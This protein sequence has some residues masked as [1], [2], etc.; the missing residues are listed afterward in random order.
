M[1]SE[2]SWQTGGAG[3]TSNPA[4]ADS[5]MDQS[6]VES[7]LRR[8]VE[9]VE[10][11]ERRYS[12]ALDELHARLDQISQTTGAARETGSP[13]DAATLDR[14]HT[15]VSSLARRLGQDAE[16]SLDD[17]ERLGKALSRATELAAEGTDEPSPAAEAPKAP[18]SVTTESPEAG[19]ESSANRGAP[20]YDVFYAAPE[21][22]PPLLSPPQSS[23]SPFAGELSVFDT[24]ETFSSAPAS[25]PAVQA[26]PEPSYSLAPH[27]PQAFAP[28]EHAYSTP[29]LEGSHLSSDTEDFDKRLLAMAHEFEHTIGAAMPASTVEALHAR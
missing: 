1:A 17:F 25:E 2:A 26:A 28:A 8:L 24:P 7:L 9:R 10:E 27:E 16:T 12:E 19:A 4:S 18:A 6:T 11:S 5:P 22:E 20:G 29:E 13:E 21:S 15:Q 23:S 3:R 14:L